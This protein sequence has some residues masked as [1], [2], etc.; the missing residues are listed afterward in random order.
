LRE[1]DPLV[2]CHFCCLVFVVMLSS[3]ISQPS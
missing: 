2:I 3:S 1:C